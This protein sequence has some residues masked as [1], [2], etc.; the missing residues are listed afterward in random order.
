MVEHS[1]QNSVRFAF[2]K[3]KNQVHLSLDFYTGIMTQTSPGTLATLLTPREL[4]KLQKQYPTLEEC[5]E[6]TGYEFDSLR[7]RSI[8]L[9]VRWQQEK[10]R[11]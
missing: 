8:R 6:A 4:Q 7:Q 1:A 5:C 10:K 11:R 3:L 2:I 9:N